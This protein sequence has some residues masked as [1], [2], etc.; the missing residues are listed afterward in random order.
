MAVDY[1]T[2]A[3]LEQMASAGGKPLHESTPEEAR[4]LGKAFAEMAGPGA[5]DGP[6]RRL[7]GV[8]RRRHD[9]RPGPG[10]AAGR[11]RA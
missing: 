4:A 5:D 9:H 1:A 6:G 10:A 11:P 8:G 2:K 3:I 7:P